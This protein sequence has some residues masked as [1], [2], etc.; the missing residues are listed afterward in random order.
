MKSLLKINLISSMKNL[1]KKLMKLFSWLRVRKDFPSPKTLNINNI[2]NYLEAEYRQWKSLS[3]D[4]PSYITEQS[5]YRLE[6]IKEK[7]PKCLELGSCVNCG[8]DVNSKSF[9]S[10]GCEFGCYGERLSKE[11]WET[12]KKQN[13][14]TI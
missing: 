4:E 10:Q 14:V 6:Q 9:E 7:S 13:N 2:F 3:E 5:I 8:C 12:F 11:D 1:V